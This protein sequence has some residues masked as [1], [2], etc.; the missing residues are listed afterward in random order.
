MLVSG[1]SA[2]CEAA[3]VKP[4]SAAE[5][6]LGT[7]AFAAL[8]YEHGAQLSGGVLVLMFCVAVIVPR[9]VEWL[10]AQNEA[11]KKRD[12]HAVVQGAVAQPNY[13]AATPA[14]A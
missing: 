11:K 7:E 9:V 13:M 12:V 1:I 4:L 5:S 8:L 6:N 10:K 2:L 3:K 14:P